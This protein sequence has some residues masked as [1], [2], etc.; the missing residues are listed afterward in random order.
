MTKEFK[1][2]NCPIN[3]TQSVIEQHQI[4]FWEVQGTDTVVSKESHLES[5]GTFDDSI[6]SV[7]TEE[8]FTTIDFVRDKDI[9]NYSKTRALE[10]NY[11]S[12]INQINDLGATYDSP[13]PKKNISWCLFIILLIFWVVPG[14]IY[15]MYYKKKYKTINKERVE[16]WESLREKMDNLF[17][18]NKTILN[19]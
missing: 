12:L 1:H 5:G 3:T 18:E 17:M 11:Y 6:Y 2:I 8:R 10:S 9:P 15:Y 13:P 19:I 16:E 7:T 14:I 4:F